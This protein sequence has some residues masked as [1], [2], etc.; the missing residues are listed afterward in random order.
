MNTLLDRER[1]RRRRRRRGGRRSS[2]LF[3]DSFL[4]FGLFFSF[5]MRHKIDR[6]RRRRRKSGIKL[7]KIKK[8]ARK[9]KN[10]F[11]DNDKI[12]DFFVS[13]DIVDSIGYNYHLHD[14]NRRV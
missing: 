4:L 1:E 10:A 13:L 11:Q 8:R 5:L 7:N 3:S 2:F 14:E 12:T 9:G 6:R